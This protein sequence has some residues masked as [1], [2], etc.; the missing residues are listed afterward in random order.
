[1]SRL[2]RHVAA[3][4]LAAFISWSFLISGILAGLIIEIKYA[5]VGLFL[6][7]L[8]QWAKIGPDDELVE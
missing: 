5:L 4:R 3:Y 6:F 1:M 8:F 7:A 2:S